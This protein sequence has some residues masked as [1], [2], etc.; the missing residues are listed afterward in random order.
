MRS[1][2]VVTALAVLAALAP[3]AVRADHAGTTIAW[4]A[5]LPAQPGMPA[6]DAASC[7]E[8]GLRCLRDVERRLA[9]MAE[10]FGCDHRGVFAT[11][12]LL[13]TRELRVEAERRPSVFEDPAAIGR[14][15]VVFFEMYT[16]ALADHEAGR[17]LPAAWRIAFDA[18]RD[19]D[20]NAGQ[21]MLLAISAHVQHDM[22]FAV[23]VVGLRTPHGGSRKPDHD[24]VNQVLSRA[25]DRIVPAIAERYD[26]IM[27]TADAKPSPADDI[28]A[29]NMVAGW[30]EG[31]WRN[32][33]RLTAA[34]HA[35]ERAAVV[36]GIE[37]NAEAWARTF[38][39]FESPGYRATR[40]AYCRR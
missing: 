35:W 29:Q 1:I 28:A 25:Y 7:G 19:G 33:E 12:Y 16:R 13:L 26:P 32:A 38:A 22:P 15:A 18:A 39:A 14:L 10:E 30:R 9:R 37:R 6:R 36:H 11:T 27:T 34:R 40:D 17:P 21:D 23:A 20:H 3:S 5:L 24:R 31:V 2:V 8:D 4:T